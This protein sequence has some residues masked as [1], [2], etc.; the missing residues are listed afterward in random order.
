VS[1][2]DK[3]SIAEDSWPPIF[4]PGT[5]LKIIAIHSDIFYI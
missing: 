5:L 3:D 1:S 2:S 4:K